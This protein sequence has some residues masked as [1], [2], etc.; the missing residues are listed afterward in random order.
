[1]RDPPQCLS[2]WD[3]FTPS[4]SIAGQTFGAQSVP[5]STDAPSTCAEHFARKFQRDGP[6][7]RL[8][9]RSRLIPDQVVPASCPRIFLCR[10]GN[11]S[12]CAIRQSSCSFPIRKPPVPAAH[13]T[14]GGRDRDEE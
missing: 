4:K 6:A 1:M 14:F 8:K 12:S 11:A 13:A 5:F 10:L 3:E 9:A 7:S 2:M